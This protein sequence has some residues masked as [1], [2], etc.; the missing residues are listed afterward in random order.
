VAEFTLPFDSLATNR[1]LYCL[2]IEQIDTDTPLFFGISDFEAFGKKEGLK[3]RIFH[4]E[5]VQNA[6][7][8]LTEAAEKQVFRLDAICALCAGEPAS[9][10]QL[11]LHFRK[12]VFLRKQVELLNPFAINLIYPRTDSVRK[13]FL[14][15]QASLISS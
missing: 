11:I 10:E 2:M 14:E 13:F 5:K 4:K 3:K 12:W 6:W 1:C 15:F 8:Y 7:K 9:C